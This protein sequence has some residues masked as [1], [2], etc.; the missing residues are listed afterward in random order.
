MASYSQT[1][2][3]ARHLAQQYAQGARPDAQGLRAI[4]HA[5][6]DQAAEIMELR[7]QIAARC[8]DA[9]ARDLAHELAR[10]NENLR[11]PK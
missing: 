9:A 4:H 6:E 10:E 11:G 7:D 1:I 3:N 5:M 2:R 8:G